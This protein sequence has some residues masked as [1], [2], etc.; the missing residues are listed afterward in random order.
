MDWLVQNRKTPAVLQ[1]SWGNGSLSQVE[2]AAVD[3]A[4][5]AGSLSSATFASEEPFKQ[6]IDQARTKMELAGKPK[7]EIEEEDN[8]GADLY[9]GAFSLAYGTLT[10]LR[11]RRCT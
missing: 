1:M 6:V 5:D 3:A 11:A 4:V 7:E 2:V 9:K 10:L 8:E